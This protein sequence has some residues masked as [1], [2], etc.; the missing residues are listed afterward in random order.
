M[1][2]RLLLITAI[3][4]LFYM[5]MGWW[6]AKR[7]NRI[8]TVD[9][10]WGIGFVLAAVVVVAQEPSLRSIVVASLVSIW[11]IRLSSHLI[12]RSAGRQEDPRYVEIKNKW[13]GNAWLRAYFSI[14]LL[15]GVLIF[16]VSSVTA[17]AAGTYL[18]GWEWLTIVGGVVWAIGF[19]FEAIGDAQLSTFVAAKKAG[20]TD[21]HIMDQGLWKYSRH[22]N[23]FGELTQ[24]WGIGIIALQTS[25]GWLGLFG[26]L[27]LTVLIVF[28]SGIPTSEKHRKKDPEFRDYMRRTSVLIPL[29]PK[30]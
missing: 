1:T 5:T 4:L 9:S 3:A 8:D 6:L 19:A 21:K 22:P 11:G 23:Y 10:M 28:V 12:A 25:F 30:P 16:I 13:V 17:Y 2:A 27:V 7:R 14:F 26:P 20:T 18:G 29:P 15:Q 24:W